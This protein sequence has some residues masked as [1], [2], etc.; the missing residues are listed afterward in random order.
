MTMKPK[1]ENLLIIIPPLVDYD[2][3][4]AS[5]DGKPDFENERLCSPI[6]P[7][8]VA[9]DLKGRGVK[10]HIVDLGISTSRCERNQRAFSAI[11]KFKPDALVVVQSIHTFISSEEW[12]GEAIFEHL[13]K[14]NPQSVGILTGA[15]ATNFPGRAVEDGLCAFSI[16][17][18][19][20]LSVGELVSALNEGTSLDTIRG[21]TY[22]G[23]DGAVKT[24]EVYPQVAPEHLPVPDYSVLDDLH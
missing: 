9:A 4:E 16:R 7:A 15:H 20:D 21:L 24:S 18:E 5:T 23:D 8:T 13:H 10:V 11:D 22:Q 17:G 3:D 14:T 12:L 6:D 1:I 2:S 19:P